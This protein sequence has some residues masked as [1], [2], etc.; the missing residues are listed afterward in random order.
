M[1]RTLA[2]MLSCILLLGGAALGSGCTSTHNTYYSKDKYRPGHRP[3]PRRD[4][5]PDRRPDHK[6]DRPVHPRPDGPHR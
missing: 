1:T 2:L 5:K 6:P 4:W 3:P